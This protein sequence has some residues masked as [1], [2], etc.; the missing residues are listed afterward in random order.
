MEVA[1]VG[2]PLI[3]LLDAKGTVVSQ[4]PQVKQVR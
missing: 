1:A 3:K 4:M 2:I